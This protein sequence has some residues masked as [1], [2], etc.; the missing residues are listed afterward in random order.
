[1]KM[2]ED[3]EIEIDDIGGDISPPEMPGSPVSD[4]SSTLPGGGG[5]RSPHGLDHAICI[6]PEGDLLLE[7]DCEYLSTTTGQKELRNFI[8]RVSKD[9]LCSGSPLLKSIISG[10]NKSSSIGVLRSPLFPHDLDILHIS[11]SPYGG[12]LCWH[13]P[14]GLNRDAITTICEILHSK[15]GEM[16]K[17]P[18][19]V[20][21]TIAAHAYGL[22]C[23]N[24]LVPAF[25]I[26]LMQE[27]VLPRLVKYSQNGAQGMSTPSMIPPGPED[28]I[29]FLTLSYVF[30]DPP[31][32]RFF[33]RTFMSM[34]TVEKIGPGMVVD[35]GLVGISRFDN[36]ITKAMTAYHQGMYDIF[37]STSGC[38]STSADKCCSELALGALL[39]STK[40]V[41]GSCDILLTPPNNNPNAFT[42]PSITSS[43]TVRSYAKSLHAV[44]LA[45]NTRLKELH[46]GKKIISHHCNW[47]LEYGD[48][49]SDL[50][51]KVEK[52]FDGFDLLDYIATS[53][54]QH[55]H[56]HHN[57]GG[58]YH[59]KSTSTYTTNT[60]AT[61]HYNYSDN[62]KLINLLDP[63]GTAAAALLP[64]EESL[65]TKYMTTIE[66][67]GSLD[68]TLTPRFQL[69]GWRLWQ[70]VGEARKSSV[71]KENSASKP[72]SS[73]GASTYTR[74]GLLSRAGTLASFKSR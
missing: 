71:A 37:T 24:T 39:T 3:I 47:L 63:L 51:W 1:M 40:E 25:R 53:A 15:P 65:H 31:A 33:S 32:F 12:E 18:P 45:V 23:V 21:A 9:S 62:R 54:S 10:H 19:H 38:V 26:C 57:H 36:H 7:A 34:R 22:G 28:S 50:A 8:W 27:P 72:A 20:L 48:K 13:P 60:T 68:P 56:P 74:S 44:A 66:K 52:E 11:F 67:D 46:K 42:A 49:I 17:L 14:E 61:S 16:E 43:G 58:N 35:P 70:F 73:S 5:G 69:D 59:K 41:F 29:P 64:I 55:S 6:D 2:A 4:V 30:K